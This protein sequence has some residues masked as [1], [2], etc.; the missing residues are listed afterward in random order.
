MQLPRRLPGCNDT[1]RIEIHVPSLR[2]MYSATYY[3]TLAG[4]YL[5]RTSAHD[6]LWIRAPHGPLLKV[7][8]GSLAREIGYFGYFAEIFVQ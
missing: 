2:M 5:P 6:G 4:T 3:S 1:L 8:G 7:R